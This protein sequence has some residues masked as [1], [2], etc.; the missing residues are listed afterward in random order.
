MVPKHHA[1]L[2]LFIPYVLEKKKVK[3]HKQEFLI[4]NRAR[5]FLSKSFEYIVDVLINHS[6]KFSRVVQS[7]SPSL[8]LI[9]RYISNGRYS[10][11][12]KMFESDGVHPSTPEVIQAL[13]DKHSAAPPRHV[14]LTFTSLCP[15]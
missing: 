15:I 9:R 3:L 14:P 2:L 1:V 4:K 13:V 7:T 6:V 11:A 8:A 12:M 5:D 10:T